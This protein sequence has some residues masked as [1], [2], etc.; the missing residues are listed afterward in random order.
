MR[1]LEDEKRWRESPQGLEVQVWILLSRHV[2]DRKRDLFQKYIACH[3]YRDSHRQFCP[4][5]P[6]QQGVYSNG[7]C[8]LM[9]LRVTR[10]F[11]LISALTDEEIF[12][13]GN[14]VT[15]Y[16]AENY[17]LCVSI[18]QLIYW[19]P[20]RFDQIQTDYLKPALSGESLILVVSQYSQ[21][22]SSPD[23][24]LNN[25]NHRE[26]SISLYEG[27]RPFHAF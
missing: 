13:W 26:L 7:E 9:R 23:H 17:D 10:P 12:L 1:C 5:P 21:K 24:P 22:V 19:S 16:Q 27:V 6:V 8:A 14:Q 4:P 15:H 18:F 2:R 20:H 25:H 3:V 11:R